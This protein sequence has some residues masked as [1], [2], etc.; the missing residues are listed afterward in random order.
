LGWIVG[1]FCGDCAAYD[2]SAV[3]VILDARRYDV[4][5]SWID[6]SIRK[7]PDVLPALPAHV[8]VSW[9]EQI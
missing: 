3:E 9:K 5:D 8:E 1:L 7:R 4:V 2:T 6:L